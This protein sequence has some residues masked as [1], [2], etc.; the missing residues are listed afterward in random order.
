MDLEQ[1]ETL[2]KLIT[3]LKLE[4]RSRYTIKNY[5]HAVSELFKFSKKKP[6]DLTIQDA[7]DYLVTLFGSYST[8]SISLTASAI[9]YFY[10]EVLGLAIGKIKIP[11]RERLLPEVLTKD[12]VYKIIE[13]AKTKKAQLILELMYTAGMRVSEVVS[14]QKKDVNL[15]TGRARIKGK[16]NRM[17]QVLIPPNLLAE[18]KSFSD[19]KTVYFFSDNKPMTTRNV[20]KILHQISKRLHMNKKVTPHMLRHSYATHLLEDGVDIRVIQSLLGHKNLAT[21]EIYT[22]VT[23]SLLKK[24][25]GNIKKLE[26]PRK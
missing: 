12:E 26:R 6:R 4:G 21:T 8:S 14:L 23:D 9:R 25:E 24:A 17:R 15:I 10:G 16:G 18:L 2:A 7:R 11:R 13:A 3:E 20:Q 5:T 1:K 19:T 22:Q